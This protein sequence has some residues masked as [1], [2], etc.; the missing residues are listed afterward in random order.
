MVS[1]GALRQ[2]P[3]R[4]P[5]TAIT[6]I[7]TL[8]GGLATAGTLLV[9]I[10][11]GV[12][13]GSSGQGPVGAS[14]EELAR[15]T[16]LITAVDEDGKE[17]WFG[18]GSII[19]ED[20]LILTAAHNVEDDELAHD[21]LEVAI[22]ED[23]NKPPSGNFRATVEAVDST[24]DLALIR[25]DAPNPLRYVRRS[26][27][28]PEILDRIRILGYSGTGGE[29][30]TASIGTV[31]GFATE[32][33]E[34]N[35]RAWIKTDAVVTGGAS[36]GMAVN[37]AGKLIGVVVE[38]GSGSD[39]AELVDCRVGVADTNGDGLW[40]D[41]DGCLPLGGFINAIRPI[42]LAE[43]LIRDRTSYKPDPTPPAETSAAGETSDALFRNLAFSTLPADASAADVTEICATWEYSGM[44]D[45]M[46]WDAIWYVGAWRFDEFSHLRQ[47]WEGGADGKSSDFHPVCIVDETGLPDGEYELNISVE[48][49]LQV[50]ETIR[51][52]G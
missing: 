6:A 18:S 4:L 21:H 12:F 14:V 32:S 51:I 16:V 33:D 37:D 30:L 23:V 9:L 41:A 19:S 28:E 34:I 27:S 2:R 26:E 10:A 3:R 20:G 39:D 45:G 11:Q 29:T 7:G 15:A 43:R 42:T 24:R 36:G 8:V 22:T 31:S 46:R 13:N 47:R 48:G 40:D 1:K 44:S 38:F 25:I 17:V 50:V 5:W 52:G 49:A 35:G